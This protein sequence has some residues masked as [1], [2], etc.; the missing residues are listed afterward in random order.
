MEHLVNLIFCKSVKFQSFL[1]FNFLFK[2]IK[3]SFFKL[4]MSATSRGRG[5]PPKAFVPNLAA[6]GR[7]SEKEK[8]EPNPRY[9]LL[10]F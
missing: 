7:R 1:H 2:L 6:A 5:R 10:V 9:S 8:V 3:S 4:K